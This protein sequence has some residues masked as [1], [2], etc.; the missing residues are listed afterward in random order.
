MEGASKLSRVAKGLPVLIFPAIG[1]LRQ[2]KKD[3][4]ARRRAG[5]DET[6]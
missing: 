5:H 3:V 1:V 4:D 6:D 2:R